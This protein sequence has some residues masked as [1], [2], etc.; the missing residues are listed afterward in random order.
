MFQNFMADSS[1]SQTFQK[2]SS[3][4]ELFQLFGHRAWFEFLLRPKG[5]L[6]R[7]LASHTAEDHAIQQTV[8]T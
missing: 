5:E 2:L 8:A 3:L 7:G 4:C 1:D 6:A